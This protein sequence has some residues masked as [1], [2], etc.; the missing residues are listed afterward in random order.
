[1]ITS[2]GIYL[3]FNISFRSYANQNTPG[4]NGILFD[5]LDSVLSFQVSILKMVLGLESE[6]CLSMI[7]PF[8]SPAVLAKA[9]VFNK[10]IWG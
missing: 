6:F 3:W 9:W 10:M 1:M 8:V 2:M 7:D 4:A 5:F